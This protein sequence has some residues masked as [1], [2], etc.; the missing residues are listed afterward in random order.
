[1]AKKQVPFRIDEELYLTL[2]IELLKKGISFQQY[3]EALILKDVEE[4][5][6]ENNSNIQ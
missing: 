4:S 5:K 1:M 3:L 2:R 6:N